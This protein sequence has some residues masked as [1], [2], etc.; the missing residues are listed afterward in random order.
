MR[1]RNALLQEIESL[2][3]EYLG[4][5]IDFVSYLKHKNRG[6]YS[7]EVS[8]GVSIGNAG[9]VA[10][11]VAGGIAET[12]LMSESSLAKDWNT[13]EEDAAWLLL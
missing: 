12:M 5:V 11:G 9:G 1:D 4:A 10:G 3:V 7:S 13:P 8:E 6:G 2:P